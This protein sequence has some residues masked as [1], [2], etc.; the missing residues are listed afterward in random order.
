MKICQSLLNHSKGV[1][2]IRTISWRVI[3]IFLIAIFCRVIQ[4]YAGERERLFSEGNLFYQNGKHHEALKTYQK[5]LDTG[6]ESGAVY[7]NMGNCYYKLHDIG[8]AILYY[9]RAKRLMP[10]DED[11]KA[12]L[13]LANLAVVDKI[14]PRPQFILFRMVRVFIHLLPRSILMW[15][16][17]GLYLCSVGSLI[18]WIVSRKRIFRLMGF[19]LGVFSGILFLIFGLSLISRLREEA[20]TVEG[21][22]LMDK[23]DVMSAPSGDGGVEVF[24]LHEGAKVRI[25]QTSGEWLKIVLADGKIGWVKWNALE[26]I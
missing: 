7:Y 3:I 5:I 26:I 13:A 24:S 14:T 12:N 8:R 22:I 23:V 15:G 11:L 1:D 2:M 19:R 25:D 17:I 4:S 16:V 20:K 10:E 9:E 21:I 18:V 6:Y